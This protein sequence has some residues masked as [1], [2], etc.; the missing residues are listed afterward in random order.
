VATVSR[1]PIRSKGGIEP[2]KQKCNPNSPIQATEIPFLWR[3][4]PALAA[5]PSLCMLSLTNL[6]CL[7]TR[8][9]RINLDSIGKPCNRNP[10]STTTK[11]H[12]NNVLV[13]VAGSSSAWMDEPQEATYARYKRANVRYLEDTAEKELNCKLI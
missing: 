3:A 10:C 11:T 12:T 6:A 7:H 8:S 5:H 9:L 13:F 2:L 4:I 1:Y